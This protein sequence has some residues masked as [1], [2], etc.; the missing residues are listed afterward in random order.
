M[1]PAIAGTTAVLWAAV[2]FFGVDAGAAMIAGFIPARASG[3][4]DLPGAIPSALTP[5]SAT[6]VHAGFMHLFF[7][8]LMLLVTGRAIEPVL[9][10][11]RLVI[12]YVLGAYAAA[13]AQWAIDPASPVPMVGASGAV[14]ALVAAYALFYGRQRVRHP[15][16]RIARLLGVLWLAAG[17]IGIQLLFDWWAGAATGLN[18]ATAAHVGGFVG[19]LVLTPLLLRGQGSGRV[20]TA[21]RDH[22]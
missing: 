1:V 9:G 5:L 22:E 13:G 16:P 18:I 21:V 11:A 17:W 6:L 4:V 20:G 15:N 2:A 8:M 7:N 19:G 3:L 12:L 14:S 10:G